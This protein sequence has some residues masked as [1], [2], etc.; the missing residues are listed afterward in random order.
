M[1]ITQA[2]AYCGCSVNHFKA[3]IAPYLPEQKWLFETSTVYDKVDIDKF[4]E[5]KKTEQLAAASEKNKIITGGTRLSK[6]GRASWSQK[7]CQ[8]LRFAAGSGTFT[9]NT[10]VDKFAEALLL[11]TG[12]KP[13]QS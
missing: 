2:A 5:D 1:R 3:K 11:V 10:G 9:N 8:D 4:I 6:K 12:K 13:K 7:K